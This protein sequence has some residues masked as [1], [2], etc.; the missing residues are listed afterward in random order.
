MHVVDWLGAVNTVVLLC[1]SATMVIV[2]ENTRR[3]NPSRAKQ[4]L[5]VTI[6][7]GCVFLGMKA[8]EYQSKF[9]HGLYPRAPKSLIY[10]HA[11]LSFLSGVRAE[12]DD[13]IK[14]GAD[15]KVA[16][17]PIAV[18]PDSLTLGKLQLIQSGLVHW[19]E[20]TVGRTN[21]VL[22]QQRS[23]ETLAWQLYPS[24]FDETTSSRAQKFLRDETNENRQQLDALNGQ[25][26][27]SKTELSQIQTEL[28]E[29]QKLYK[30]LDAKS[31]DDSV[32][33]ARMGIKKELTA[34]KRRANAATAR[35]TALIVERDFVDR[36]IRAIEDLDTLA[37]QNST[38]GASGDNIHH[39]QGINERFGLKLPMVI[40]GGNTWT[41]TYF[42]LTGF[43]GLHVLVGIILLIALA[44]IRLDQE[45]T[46]LVENVGLY[47]HF[48]DAVWIILF[49]IIYLF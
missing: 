4:L 33:T 38:D 48:V 43:H 32:K 15:E 11:N 9:Q 29:K 1:S 27:Q 7:F 24:S 16:G 28:A 13:L 8:W 10:D 39:D 30:K 31:K 37:T 26:V 18:Q 14:Q 46:G 34:I 2:F 21:D 49:P 23:L 42:L 3:N 35:S 25:V 36:R 45:R 19:T 47:W 41:N 5:W 6:A 12:V 22:M 17:S 44:T 40:P 20:R